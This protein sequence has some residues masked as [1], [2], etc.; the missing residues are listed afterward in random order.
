MRH[1]HEGRFS[2]ALVKR[3]GMRRPRTWF[4]PTMSGRLGSS[5]GPT[6]WLY[7][8]DGWTRTGRRSAKAGRIRDA[9]A[10]VLPRKHDPLAQNRR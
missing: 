8:F 7:R 3:N 1:V 2:R 6:T 9:T 5:S 10:P 4:A